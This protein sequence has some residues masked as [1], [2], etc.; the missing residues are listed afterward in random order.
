MK[1]FRHG[2]LKLDNASATFLK[3]TTILVSMPNTY[4]RN[5]LGQGFLHRLPGCGRHTYVDD[6]ILATQ[7]AVNRS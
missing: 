4:L 6:S 1:L 3:N 5:P 7:A 2:V